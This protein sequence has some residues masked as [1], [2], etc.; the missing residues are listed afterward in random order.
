MPGFGTTLARLFMFQAAWGY[1][2]MGGIG[3]AHS[4]EPALRGLEGGPAGEAYRRALARETAFFNAHPYFAALAVGAAARAELD[5]EAPERIMKL[6]EALCGPLGS[7]GDRLIWAAWLPGC[8]AI[9]LIVV[10]LGGG[11]LGALTFLALYNVVHVYTRI[12]AL[13]AGWSHGLHVAGALTARG[14]RGANAAAP[15]VA[16]FLVGAALPLVFGWQMRGAPWPAL[17]TA[18]AAAALFVF[19]VRL[20]GARTS[21]VALAAV[22]LGA[23]WLAGLVWW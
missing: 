8:V 7:I 13:R 6:R 10:A 22:L 17:L 21:G 12:W 11:V 18:G 4:I 1:E 5:G 14:L 20:A 15:P 2:R 3:F 23:T 16:A 19:V 9:G